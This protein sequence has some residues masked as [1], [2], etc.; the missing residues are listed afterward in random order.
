MTMTVAQSKITNSDAML[1]AA[2]RAAITVP[3]FG[4][5]PVPNQDERAR[6]RDFLDRQKPFKAK[7]NDE[8]LQRLEDDG[9]VL[10]RLYIGVDGNGNPKPKRIPENEIVQVLMS[11]ISFKRV[12]ET[13]SDYNP[14]MIYNPDT[15]IYAERNDW[16]QRYAAIVDPTIKMN[17]QREVHNQLK[18]LADF[19][20][21]TK[22]PDLAV[23]GN[24]IFN[25]KTKTL[26]PFSPE[27]VFLTKASVNWVDNPTEPEFEDGWTFE[28]FLDEQ[29]GDA[30]DAK[31]MVYQILQGA[32]LTNRPKL[33]FIYLFSAKGRTGKGTLTELIRS[34]VGYENSGSANIEQLEQPFGLES[35]YDKAFIFGNEN[36]NVFARTSVNIKN[37][38]SGDAVTVNRKNITNISISATP[39]IVQ[40]MNTTPT[41]LGL[42]GGTKN[43]MRILEFKH[44]Y[45]DDDNIAVKSDYVHNKQLLEYLAHKVLLMPVGR[46]IDPKM[47]QNIKQSI[48][49]DSDAVFEWYMTDFEA[50]TGREFGA[51]VLFYMFEAWLVEQNRKDKVSQRAFVLRLQRIANGALKFEPKHGNAQLN[52][53]DAKYIQQRLVATRVM[54][55]TVNIKSFAQVDKRQSTFTKIDHK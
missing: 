19:A 47:S 24:G 44:S 21:P 31:L 18:Y 45:Y 10:R 27:Y 16:V 36:D 15:G 25:I 30:E 33:V 7:S 53:H 14:L 46:M 26:M 34:L 12:G 8:L 22:D 48:E 28:N 38:A 5:D 49:M 51:K 9:R 35:V 3:T 37:L 40:S 39:L 11:I 13:E 43:R 29:F 2:H 42:D 6:L 23:L 41:F 20:K 32:L 1:A 52:E 50:L 17:G 55:P 4:T 54:A